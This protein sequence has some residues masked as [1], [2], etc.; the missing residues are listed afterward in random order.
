MLGS[1]GNTDAL[2]ET[3]V[4]LYQTELGKRLPGADIS[5]TQHGSINGHEIEVL[6]EDDLDVNPEDYHWDQAAAWV[7]ALEL[8]D[9]AEKK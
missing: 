9:C 1:E 4:E 6:D 3:M 2:I 7:A 8:L 5:V